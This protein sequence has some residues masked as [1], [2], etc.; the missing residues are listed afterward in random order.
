MSNDVVAFGFKPYSKIW[1]IKYLPISAS[2]S[3]IF[4]NDLIQRNTSGVA[5]QATATSTTI[6]GTSLLYVPAN[7]GALT[8]FDAKIAYCPASPMQEFV[9]VMDDASVSALTDFDLN[10]DIVVGSGSTVTGLSAMKIDASTKAATAT[11]PIKLIR[12]ADGYFNQDGTENALGSHA[13]V[14]CKINQ[15]IYTA[16]VNG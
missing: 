13:K 3:A 7:A 12:L 15:S 14:I 10:Y 4:E 11:L 2:N 16:G 8:S 6:A 5:E 9:C 1:S